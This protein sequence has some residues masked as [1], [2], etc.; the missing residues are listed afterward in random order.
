MLTT[1]LTGQNFEIINIIKYG[2][3][4]YIVKGAYVLKTG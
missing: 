4:E 1:R 2:Q 3:D